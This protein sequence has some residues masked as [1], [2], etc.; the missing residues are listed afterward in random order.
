MKDAFASAISSLLSCAPADVTVTSVTENTAG[1]RSLQAA[2]AVTVTFQ[3]A[4]ASAGAASGMTSTLLTEMGPN[5]TAFVVALQAASPSFSGVTAVTGA[6]VATIRA[7][8]PPPSPSPPTPPPPLANWASLDAGETIA[9]DVPFDIFAL[10]QDWY[11]AAFVEAI[12]PL[13]A[14]EPAAVVVTN[15]LPSSADTTMIYFSLSLPDYSSDGQ[16]AI[17]ASN[18][19]VR[20]LFSSSSNGAPAR[21]ALVAALR[22]AGIPVRAAYYYDQPVSAASNVDGTND[23]DAAAGA[24][25]TWSLA[26]RGMTVALAVPFA[27]FAARQAIWGTAFA[28]AVAS[29]LGTP[30]DTVEITGFQPSTVGTTLI[31]FDVLLPGSDS[32]AAIPMANVELQALFASSETG[33]PALP[34][35]MAALAEQGLD[36]ATVPAAY[37]SDQLVPTP[38][39]SPAQTG[40][41]LRRSL[42]RLLD[43]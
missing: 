43:F 10:R 17:S 22:A 33:A 5:S 13:L 20:A 15:F 37:L 31:Y 4:A 14:T 27:T 12:A 35:F 6:E 26:A 38:T 28:A 25:G 21:P 39:P 7:T 34:P 11:K 9:I 30:V 29:C 32:S 40:R 16:S 8:P 42:R 19:R 36:A 2:D 3:V 41:R 1:R 18:I 23:S 24:V